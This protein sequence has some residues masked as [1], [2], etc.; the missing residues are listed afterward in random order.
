MVRH[1]EGIGCGSF[2]ARSGSRSLRLEV[3]IEKYYAKVQNGAKQRYFI[4]KYAPT[5]MSKLCR[6]NHEASTALLLR[7]L[8]Q[9]ALEPK[10]LHP[11][12]KQLHQILAHFVRL[13][14]LLSRN[15]G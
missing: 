12:P 13:L 15:I 11:G 1:K 5:I 6:P 2:S 7:L 9:V 8:S 10:H 3:F 4:Y 14:K